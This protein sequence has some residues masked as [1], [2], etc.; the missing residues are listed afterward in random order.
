MFNNIQTNSTK[1]K[2]DQW[3]SVFNI[4][5]ASHVFATLKRLVLEPLRSILKYY[6]KTKG[7]R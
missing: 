3:T 6:G 5:G 2:K 4:Y 1:C 7:Q